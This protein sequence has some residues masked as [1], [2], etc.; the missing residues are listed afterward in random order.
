MR[1]YIFICVLDAFLGVSR[2]FY[3][4][5]IKPNDDSNGHLIYKLSMDQILVTMKYQSI[6][7]PEDLIEAISETDS[8]DNKIQVNHFDSDHSIVQDDHSNNHNK[9]GRIHI[10]HTNNPKDPQDTSK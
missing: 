7:V 6:P 9:N 4:F 3:A 2:R 1:F 10:N 8:S 5:Y